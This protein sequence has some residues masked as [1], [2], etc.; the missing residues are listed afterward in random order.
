MGKGPGASAKYCSVA[1]GWGGVFT[2]FYG[3]ASLPSAYNGN[4]IDSLS[5]DDWDKACKQIFTFKTFIKTT[6]R[7][8]EEEEDGKIYLRQL[9]DGKVV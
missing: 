7:E 5:R 6:A 4:F 8:R 1:L 2:F 9:E 3:F